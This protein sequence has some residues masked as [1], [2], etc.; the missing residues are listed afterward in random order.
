[1]KICILIYPGRQE[2]I[3]TAPKKIEMIVLEIIVLIKQEHPMN[4]L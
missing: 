2:L 3:K 1:M 4:M